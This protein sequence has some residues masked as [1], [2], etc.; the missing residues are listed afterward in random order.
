[1]TIAKRGSSTDSASRCDSVTVSTAAVGA[2]SRTMLRTAGAM[3]AGSP[4]V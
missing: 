2:S 4:A 1:M 3:A